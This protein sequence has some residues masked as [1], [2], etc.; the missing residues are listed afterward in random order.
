VPDLGA[1]GQVAPQLFDQ[2]PGSISGPLNAG[3]T[4]VVAKLV[5]KQQP[6]D[7]D[8]AKNLDQVRDQILEQ[9]RQE[10][11]EIFANTIITDF[12]KKNL[13]RINAKSQSPLTGE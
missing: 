9:K 8:I 6:S 12:K 3:R 13:V 4:G 11:F 10:A 2:T 7:E 1:V 5:D